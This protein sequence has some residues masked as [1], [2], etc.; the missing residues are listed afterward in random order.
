MRRCLLLVLQILVL[1]AFAGTPDNPSQQQANQLLEQSVTLAEQFSPGDHV[2]FLYTLTS[3]AVDIAPKSKREQWCT[4]MFRLASQ[5]EPSWNRVAQ[6]KNALICLSKMNATLAMKRFDEV[7]LPQPDEDGEFPEDLRASAAFTIFQNYW[8]VAGISGLPTIEDRANHIGDTGEYPYKAMGQIIAAMGKDS[9]TAATRKALF[10]KA[11]GYYNNPKPRPFR[12]RNAQFLKLLQ[13]TRP[14]IVDKGVFRD[15]LRIFY[16]QIFSETT[17][18]VDYAEEVNDIVFL[19][20]RRAFLFHAFDMIN[21][22]DPLWARE[23]Q[24]QYK[25]LTKATGKIE[26][27]SASAIHQDVTPEQAQYLHYKLSQETLP[28]KIQEKIDAHDIAGA[29]LLATRLTDDHAHILGVAKLLPSLAQT[30]PTT[31]ERLYAAERTRLQALTDEIE[32]VQALVALAQGAYHVGKQDEFSDLSKSAFS[33]ALRLFTNDSR[34]RPQLH[35]QVRQGY[36]ELKDIVVFGVAHDLAWI[37]PN[38]T[39]LQDVQLKADLLVAA[40]Q[41]VVQQKP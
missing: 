16:Q 40:A 23:L 8:N 30:N 25:E 5:M 6:Q 29:N 26:V 27:I 3:A 4:Q 1:H 38:I 19:D 9:S 17:K 18:D 15:A 2:Y 22:V 33:D 11:I 31:A 7:D 35:I 28:E 10:E 41:G 12:N 36:T 32:R 37:L 21:T 14:P 39:D 13:A 20:R 24:H 34:Q